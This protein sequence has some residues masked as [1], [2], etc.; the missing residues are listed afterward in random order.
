MGISDLLGWPAAYK[1]WQL[2]FQKQKM[3][4][5]AASRPPG[6]LRI[7]E[8][9]CGPGLNVPFFKKDEYLGV[10]IEPRYVAAA[11]AECRRSGSHHKAILGD[12]AHLG[13]LV[14]GSFDVVLANSLL[15]H[16]SDEEI[17]RT[18]EGVTGRLAAGGTLQI[19]DLVIDDTGSKVGNWLA[20][21][22]RGRFART[23]ANLLDVVSKRLEVIQHTRFNLQLGGLDLWNM[24][25]IIG[26]RRGA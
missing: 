7:L 23:T 25:H 14:D 10:D 20:V 26:H 1:L 22:D 5:V 13:G 18:L 8:L 19:I 4:P 2:P 17:A 3:A 16:L 15:H 21:N 24:I 9:G 6:P 12:C 11:Q